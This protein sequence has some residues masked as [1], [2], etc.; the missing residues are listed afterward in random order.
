[1]TPRE[2]QTLPLIRQGMTN[3]EIAEHLH[4]SLK[5][6][7]CHVHSTLERRG[8]R[9]KAELLVNER[10]FWEQAYGFMKKALQD[11]AE[12]SNELP[13]R[14]FCLGMLDLVGRMEQ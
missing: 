3:K 14:E 13:T 2:T 6:A 1:M 9:S 8:A 4:V 7:E 10:L 5:T 11:V 12:Q